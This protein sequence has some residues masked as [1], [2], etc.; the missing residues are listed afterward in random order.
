MVV[1]A[2]LAARVR[3]SA[4]APEAGVKVAQCID[5]KRQ[6][7]ATPGLFRMQLPRGSPSLRW[8]VCGVE[9]ADG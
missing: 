2:A 3:L 7:K 6:M 5:L 8:A 9:G 4:P 1:L